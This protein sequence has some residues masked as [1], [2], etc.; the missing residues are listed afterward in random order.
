MARPDSD[1]YDPQGRKLHSRTPALFFTRPMPV[2]HEEHHSAAPPPGRDPYSAF[3]IRA[4]TLYTVGSFIAVVGRQM[5]ATVVA[6]EIH[7]RTHSAMALGLIGLA[8]ALPIIFLALPAGQA[9]D[10]MD[11]RGL[12]MTTQALG[13]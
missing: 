12:I 10:R 1:R 4:Y 8:G 5:L 9:A 3:R 6:Y 13:L 7:T 11:R 2:F